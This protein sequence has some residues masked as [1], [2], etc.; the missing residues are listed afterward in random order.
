MDKPLIT[1]TVLPWIVTGERDNRHVKCDLTPLGIW[2]V[3]LDH[4]SKPPMWRA[5]KDG[6]TVSGNQYRDRAAAIADAER[7]IYAQPDWS[8]S[9]TGRVLNAIAAMGAAAH[10]AG[11]SIYANPMTV[12]STDHAHWA[13]GWLGSH[14]E[15]A[16]LAMADSARKVLDTVA[17][18]TAGLVGVTRVIEFVIDTGRFGASSWESVQFLIW[19]HAGEY[20]RLTRDYPEWAIMVAGPDDNLQI[21]SP[22]Y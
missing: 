17:T 6:L 10:K 7:D 22:A 9:Q 18:V 11:V 1:G 19:W 15:T 13:H 4:G 16:R 20:N 12:G 14:A 3:E 21:N 8:A 2:T 5:R